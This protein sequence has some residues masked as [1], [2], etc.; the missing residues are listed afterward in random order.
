MT[1]KTAKL[2]T[3]FYHQCVLWCINTHSS[4][5]NIHDYMSA[6]LTPRS[7]LFLFSLFSLTVSIRNNWINYR[8]GLFWISYIAVFTSQVVIMAVNKTWQPHP[9]SPKA[10]KISLAVDFFLLL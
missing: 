5:G 4:L 2:A 10:K 3:P 1:I 6:P 7:H 9:E 8:S